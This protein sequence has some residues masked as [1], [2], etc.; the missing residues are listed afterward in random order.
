MYRGEVTLQDAVVA[1]TL[2][3]CSMQSSALIGGINVLHSAFPENAELEYSAQG[4]CS[5]TCTAHAQW[6]GKQIVVMSHMGQHQI[7]GMY[8]VCVVSLHV[9]P[10]KCT[11]LKVVLAKL[12]IVALRWTNLVCHCISYTKAVIINISFAPSLLLLICTMYHHNTVLEKLILEKLCLTEL[13]TRES[14]STPSSPCNT[15]HYFNTSN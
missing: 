12:M 15:S 9:S 11:P 8:N 7:G 14:S 13:L 4:T 1:V 5:C 2:M 3:E 6:R 10:A